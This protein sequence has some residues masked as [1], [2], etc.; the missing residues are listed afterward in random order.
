MTSTNNLNPNEQLEKA[1]DNFKKA[2]LIHTRT[3][4]ENPSDKQEDISFQQT[5][6]VRKRK[7]P[8]KTLT[9]DPHSGPAKNTKPSLMRAY[10][11]SVVNLDMWH[12]EIN[13]KNRSGR[14]CPYT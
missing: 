12:R 5:P 9:I 13:A 4:L 6:I 11:R 8:K 7:T 10:A 1:A 14:R 3:R 2:Q